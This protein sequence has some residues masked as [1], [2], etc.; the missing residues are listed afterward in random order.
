MICRWK[1]S[2]VSLNRHK[3]FV[4]KSNI[5]FPKTCEKRGNVETAKSKVGIPLVDQLVGWLVGKQI[6]FCSKETPQTMKKVQ[7]WP[8]LKIKKNH[9][10]KILYKSKAGNY[11]WPRDVGPVSLNIIEQ[12]TSVFASKS[13]KR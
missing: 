11:K 10:G 12:I 8:S 9:P 2:Q 6:T 3:A 1:T 13:M 4:S 7:K 5:F